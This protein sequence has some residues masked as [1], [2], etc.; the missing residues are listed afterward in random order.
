M[1][2][3]PNTRV[4]RL[5]LQVNKALFY[6]LLP[7]LIHNI[8]IY[9]IMIRQLLLFLSTIIFPFLTTT[10]MIYPTVSAVLGRRA[11]G[12]GYQAHRHLTHIQT[13]AIVEVTQD[14][15][16]KN[17]KLKKSSKFSKFQIP[18]LASN[19]WT[20]SHWATSSEQKCLQKKI[21]IFYVKKKLKIRN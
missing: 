17:L 11:L 6:L 1:R 7:I 13:A 15:R 8:H 21:L 3:L 18:Y 4:R 9:P 14:N 12:G 20:L 19:S 10:T 2:G 5:T 16:S